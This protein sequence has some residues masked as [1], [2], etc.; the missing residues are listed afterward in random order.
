VIKTGGEAVPEG[1]LAEAAQFAV[2]YSSIWKGGLAAADCYLVRGD[3]VSKTPESGEFLRKG[4]FVIRGER[5][6]FRDTALGLAL[7]ISEGLLIGGPVSAVL[8]RADPAVQI[9]P[10]EYN[11]DD[12]AK[13]IYRLFSEK[14]EDRAYLKSIASV[15]RIVQFLPPGGSRIRSMP[16]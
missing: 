4:A 14:V 1:T 12:L 6:Y 15:D 7:G 2:S 13:R 3:Q 16:G 9:E 10:G 5:R 11:T 8:P